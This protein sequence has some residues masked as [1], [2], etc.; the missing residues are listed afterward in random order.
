MFCESN[1]RTEHPLQDIGA[2]D[3]LAV[4]IATFAGK[5]IEQCLNCQYQLRRQSTILTLLELA[6]IHCVTNAQENS[7]TKLCSR[8]DVGYQ[9]LLMHSLISHGQQH[10]ILLQPWSLIRWCTQR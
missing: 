3:M 1:S 8:K 6:V 7:S 5:A 10:P 4:G 2:Q 9:N